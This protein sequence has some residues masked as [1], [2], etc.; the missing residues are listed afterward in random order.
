LEEQ[1]IIPRTSE[2]V[3]TLAV[4][5]NEE[6]EISRPLFIRKKKSHA[7]KITQQ[8]KGEAAEVREIKNVD[9]IYMTNT[10]NKK[11]LQPPR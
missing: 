6:Q 10:V 5:T 3:P 11:K 9:R 1:N 4:T 7:Q 8:T 2:D